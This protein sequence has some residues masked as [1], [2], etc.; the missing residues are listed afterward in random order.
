M[1]VSDVE[2]EVFGEPLR[3]IERAVAGVLA[4]IAVPAH[5]ALAAAATLFL[6]V[7]VTGL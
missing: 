1:S 4:A 7:L 6:Y 3:P 5:A 2:R